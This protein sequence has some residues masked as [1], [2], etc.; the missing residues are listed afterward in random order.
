MRR[1][2]TELETEEVTGGTVTISAP[3]NTVAFKSLKKAFKIKGNI[4]E[5]RNRLIELYDANEGMDD[6][7]FDT[8]VMNEFKNNGWI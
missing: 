6:K 8:L 3:L 5:M 4:K 2:L 7:A 1:E